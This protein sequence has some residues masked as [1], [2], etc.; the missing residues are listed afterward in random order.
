MP[1][2]DISDTA[3]LTAYARAV[4]SERGDALFR[5]RH[6]AE[7]AG[8]RG[9]A[10]A[11]ESHSFSMLANAIACRTAV[12]DELL[13]QLLKSQ[14]IDLVVNVAAGLDAR[15]WRLPLAQELRWIDVDLPSVLDYKRAHLNPADARCNYSSHAA[16]LGVPE[17]LARVCT[18]FSNAQNT[19]VLTEGLLIYLPENDVARLATKLHRAASV[20][21]WITDLAGPRALALMRYTW[22]PL[23]SGARLQF[24]PQDAG[25]FFR[26]RGWCERQFRSS[27]EEARRFGRAP[28]PT[29]IGRAI[30]A[31]APM[32]AREELRRL[33]GVA[34]MQRSSNAYE[35]T[36][37]AEMVLQT[38][39]D[40]S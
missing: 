9:K 36:E 34:V 11:L 6:A 8:N 20:N 21:W 5:D 1:V 3:L 38:C 26:G 23:L 4:E 25:A 37:R 22:G 15:P 12:F 24:A 16:D 28:Q 2:Q 17:E 32:R 10:L 19:L 7:L 40:T 14:N 35:S 18:Q 39:G 31:M 33:T 27:Q 30:F 13:L 29:W